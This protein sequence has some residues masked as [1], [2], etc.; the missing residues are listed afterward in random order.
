MAIVLPL[1]AVGYVPSLVLL[2]GTV[3]LLKRLLKM[4][5]KLTAV[6]SVGSEGVSGVLSSSLVSVPLPKRVL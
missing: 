2:L 5:Y 4:L 1:P 3:P 6:V